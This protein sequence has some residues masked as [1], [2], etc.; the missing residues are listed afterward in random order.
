M[1]CWIHLLRCQD[2]S[3]LTDLGRQCNGTFCALGDTSG[4][5]F[6]CCCCDPRQSCTVIAA[7]LMN[8]AAIFK[9]VW[10]LQ[11]FCITDR[12]CG[13][14]VSHSLRDREVHGSIPG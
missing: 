6:F 3:S 12:L 14:A 13:L 1:L 8:T 7:A 2:H 9:S 11:S 5:F 10:K 4:I